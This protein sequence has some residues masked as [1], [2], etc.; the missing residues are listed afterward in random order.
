[1]RCHFLGFYLQMYRETFCDA[2]NIS[3]FNP[4]ILTLF[5]FLTSILFCVLFKVCA[6]IN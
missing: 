1:M 5:V 3:Y 2:T 6:N 4:Y